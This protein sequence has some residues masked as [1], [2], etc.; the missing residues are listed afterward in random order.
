MAEGFIFI[1]AAIAF[2]G[3]GTLLALWEIIG[4]LNKLNQNIVGQAHIV[5]D[6]KL[7]VERRW[8]AFDKLFEDSK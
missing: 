8:A 7:A 2:F 5:S 3:I 4:I 6:A 1:G